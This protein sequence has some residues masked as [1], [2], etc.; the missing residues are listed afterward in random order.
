MIKNETN[1]F[2]GTRKA[3]NGLCMGTLLPMKFGRDETLC[4][5]ILIY[6]YHTQTI[7]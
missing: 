1:M 5:N 3:S 2:E 4:Q 7:L 6:E